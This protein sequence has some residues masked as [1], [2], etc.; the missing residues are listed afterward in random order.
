[1]LLTTPIRLYLIDNNYQY[2]LLVL[3]V[4]HPN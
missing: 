2:R 4:A 3:I 1:M